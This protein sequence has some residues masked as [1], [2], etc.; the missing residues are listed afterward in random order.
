MELGRAIAPRI[1]RSVSL[2]DHRVAGRDVHGLPGAA[3]EARAAAVE[4]LRL[5]EPPARGYGGIARRER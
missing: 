3:P 1:Y 4:I 5:A 2:R